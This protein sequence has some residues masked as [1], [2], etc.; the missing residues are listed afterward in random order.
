[1]KQKSLWLLVGCPA[2]GKS[3]WANNHMSSDTIWVSRDEIRFSMV[4]E[5]EDYFSKEDEVF[6]EFVLDIQDALDKE[7]CVLADATNLHWP[8]RR[9][10]LSKL[11]LE[12]TEV[13]CVIFLTSLETC[14]ERNAKRKGRR[15]VP[16]DVLIK[17][18]NSYRH[19]KTDN[20]RYDG[21]YEIRE[22]E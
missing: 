17:M 13:Y 15:K 19:P 3:Y 21:I 5:T 6:K 22:N 16:E 8:S 18:F 2:S 12:Y 11:N 10:L 1:M 20:F 14:L 7:L 4:K 9:K